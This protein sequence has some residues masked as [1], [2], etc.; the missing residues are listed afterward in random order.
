MP[1]RGYTLETH[2]F[3]AANVKVWLWILRRRCFELQAKC[4]ISNLCILDEVRSLRIDTVANVL[5]HAQLSL[6]GGAR[7]IDVD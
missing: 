2:R 3:A 6:A 4:R 1:W 5:G 7:Q